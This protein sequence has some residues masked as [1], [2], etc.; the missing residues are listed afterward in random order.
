MVKKS[1]LTIIFCL[2]FL[3]SLSMLFSLP[4]YP[5]LNHPLRVSGNPII[6]KLTGES[7]KIWYIFEVQWFT[8]LRQCVSVRDFFNRS[9]FESP[10][11]YMGLKVI[12]VLFFLTRVTLSKWLF[13][14]QS[15]TRVFWEY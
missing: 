9:L 8:V 3:H 4:L 13:Y 10:T 12:L 11:S 2:H 14:L 5:C 15:I 6:V 1:P 7:F